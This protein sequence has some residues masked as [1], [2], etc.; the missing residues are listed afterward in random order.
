MNKHITLIMLVVAM[1]GCTIWKHQTRLTG[2]GEMN[3][4]YC[5]QATAKLACNLGLEDNSPFLKKEVN[6]CMMQEHGWVKIKEYHIYPPRNYLFVSYLHG[7][8][9]WNP[10]VPCLKD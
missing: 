3:L 8:D 10:N 1:S 4:L 5:K 6:R 7:I 2:E 9:V